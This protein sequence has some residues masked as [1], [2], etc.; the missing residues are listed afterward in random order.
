MRKHIG[1]KIIGVGGYYGS[2]KKTARETAD[3]LK[4][5][6]SW[7]RI[8]SGIQTRNIATDEETVEFMG[9]KASEEAL[10]TAEVEK[11]KIDAVIVATISNLKQSPSL[12]CKLADTLGLKDGAVAFDINAACSGFSYALSV[13][14]SM[15]TSEMAK[16]VLVVASDRM[17]DLI[18][19]H[20]RENAFLFADGAGAA[21]IT[22]NVEDHIV[23]NVLSS[24]HSLQNTVDQNLNWKE[25]VRSGK[26]ARLELNGLAIY[27]WTTNVIP[28]K[29]LSLLERCNIAVEDIKFY[30]PHQA[31]LRIIDSIAKKIGF[32]SSTNIS[33]DIV[34]HG[35]T[36]GASIPLALSSLVRGNRI[37][38]NDIVIMSGFGAGITYGINIV[39]W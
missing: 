28:K 12:A 37:K 2:I 4:V 24:E 14:K 13:A 34:E 9:A 1:A 22:A 8:R 29:I 26:S 31:N 21:I 20:D 6:E 25:A 10:R 7:I 36:S 3:E 27:R 33:R 11:D 38:N 32:T 5:E 23:A 16:M 18:D 17:T 15:I 39:R 30:I 35:N 19:K